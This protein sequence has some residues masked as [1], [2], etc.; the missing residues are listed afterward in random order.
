MQITLD[1]ESVTVV[2]G[3]GPDHV[4]LTCKGEAPIWPFDSG[5]F[6]L[7]METAAG[8]GEKYVREQ[9]GIEARVVKT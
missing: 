1:V 7:K 5:T 9:F 3:S 2:Q 6:M 4:L 8:N